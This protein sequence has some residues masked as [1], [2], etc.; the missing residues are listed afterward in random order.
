MSSENKTLTPTWIAYV[1]GAPQ[2]E[3]Q[4]EAKLHRLDKG[5]REQ[6]H[7]PNHKGNHPKKYSGKYKPFITH[8]IFYEDFKVRI[9]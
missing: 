7:R 1:D 5:I 2:M 6:D 3:V 4:I 8:V 9:K